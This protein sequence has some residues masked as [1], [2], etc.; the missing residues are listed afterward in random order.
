MGIEDEIRILLSQGHTPQSILSSYP[1]KKSTVYKVYRELSTK[2][3]PLTPSQ[4][5]VSIRPNPETKRYLPGA[6]ER[7]TCEI[8]NN[9]NL[10]LYVTGSG[11]QPEW[12]SEEWHTSSERFLLRPGESRSV[13][14]DLPI[15]QDITLGEYELHFGIEG[16]YL[17]PGNV[18]NISTTQWANPFILHIKKPF[19]GLKL[20]LSHSVEDMQLVRQLE[21]YLDS[22]G[23][24][25]F[26]A[27]DI[28]T[29]G[30]V[31]E[32]K[33]KALIRKAQFFFA[34]L[35]ENGVRSEWVIKEI[36]YAQEINRPML[37][38]KEREAQLSGSIEWVE[39]SR[40]DSQEMILETVG[41]ALSQ[42]QKNPKGIPTSPPLHPLLLIGIGAFLGSILSNA[43]KRNPSNN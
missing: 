16:Q 21:S 15:P 37:L 34:L 8:R 17:G 28:R 2:Q 20:F 27:E 10:D 39:F 9:A 42:I 5:Y 26:I 38:L 11:M 14:I 22:N 12:L 18:A 7:F 1:Y 32:E 25:V 36:N 29:P 35:T 3:M 33:F 24:E 30:A 13:R 19:N 23:I 4:W 31:L 41:E 40:F 6:S 43:G